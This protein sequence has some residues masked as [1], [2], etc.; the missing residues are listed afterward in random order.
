M[1]DLIIN[2]WAG[3]AD[4]V[5]QN[6]ADNWLYRGVTRSDH[7]LEP[8]IG[9][10]SALASGHPYSKR[11]ERKLFGEF[12]RQA[13]PLVDREDLTEL[14]WMALGQHH[15]LHT[16][17]LD[18]TE[19]VLVAAFFATESGVTKE[20]HW[21]VRKPSGEMVTYYP[22]IYGIRDLKMVSPM[23]DPFGLTAIRAYRPS[24]ISPRI[25]PQQAV[26]TIHP[27]PD[28]AFKYNKIV[29][30]T[31]KI[32]GTL[33]IKLALDASGITRASLFPGIDGLAQALNWQHKWG[34]LRV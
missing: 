13:R 28:R 21:D 2:D 23:D 25:A 29:R 26:F 5:D 1:R 4:L 14:E 27:R 33:D 18:W 8:K 31:L 3:L 6:K 32:S 24:H 34:R 19:S 7:E 11:N 12:K 15:G 9:R 17:L 10:R 22:V 20:F 16:R 30:W